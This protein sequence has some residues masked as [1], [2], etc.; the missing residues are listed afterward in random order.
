MKRSLLAAYAALAVCI[1]APAL[2]ADVNPRPPCTS[3]V[4]AAPYYD[5]SGF[6]AGIQTGASWAKANATVT[7]G[8]FSGTGSQSTTG[9][10]F[11]GYTGYN[12]QNGRFVFG[13]ELGLDTGKDMPFG[14]SLRGRLGYL[15]TDRLLAYGAGGWQFAHFNMSATGIGAWSEN[16][17]GWNVGAGLEY[18]LNQ[19]WHA[20]LEY[21][22]ADL[23]SKTTNVG[24]FGVN[25]DIKSDTVRGGITYR[26]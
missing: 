25:T 21:V 19:N 1:A 15:V 17:N 8:G 11:G 13:P 6:Y 9:W 14:A 22:H 2:A 3:C 20:R 16:R 4:P 10:N 7:F 24:A 23:G 26:F 5:W 12:W 18:A